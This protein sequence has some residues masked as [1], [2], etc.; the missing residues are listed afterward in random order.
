M[1]ISAILNG[2]VSKAGG[3]LH[4]LITA[5]LTISTGLKSVAIIALFGAL[6]LT[7]LW[8]LFGRYK[9]FPKNKT[10]KEVQTTEILKALKTYKFPKPVPVTHQHIPLRTF[11][12]LKVAA[13]PSIEPNMNL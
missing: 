6:A 3:I 7:A 1:G 5:L 9:L 12:E 4:L 8:S 11:S 10:F 2:L 13:L